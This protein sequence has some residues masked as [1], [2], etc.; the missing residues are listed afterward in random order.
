MESQYT[1]DFF[2]D[3][4]PKL[5]FDFVQ[6]DTKHQKDLSVPPLL[7]VILTC[8]CLSSNTA[9][10]GVYALHNSYFAYYE[11]RLFFWDQCLSWFSKDIQEHQVRFW[12]YAIQD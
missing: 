3:D 1:P 10:Q 12:N 2:D 4:G 11:V 7:A 8:K 9:I 6:P 5:T